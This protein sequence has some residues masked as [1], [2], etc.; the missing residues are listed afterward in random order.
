MVADDTL[1]WRLLR[2]LDDP[3]CLEVPANYQ[4]RRAR[5]R[6]NQLAQR[7]DHDFGCQCE[8]DRKVEDASFH[9]RIEISATATGTLRRLVIVISNFGGLAVLAV[10]NP[11]VWTDQEAAQLLHPDDDTRI[12]RALEDLT[13]TLIPEEPL[14]QRYDGA[15]NKD[16]VSARVNTWWDRYFD[17]L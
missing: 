17:Y 6:F 7:L 12:R 8:V 1:L 16:N 9:G 3:D 10:D 11:G 14:W 2:S 15:W 5:A 4:H 13:Y